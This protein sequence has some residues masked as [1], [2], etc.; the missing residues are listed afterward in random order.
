MLNL[1]LKDLATL[2]KWAADERSR[3]IVDRLA[4]T[5]IAEH[6]GGNRHHD[7]KIQLAQQQR[8]KQVRIYGAKENG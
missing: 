7:R 6:I 2:R 4:D 8:N 3:R 1:T 5:Y